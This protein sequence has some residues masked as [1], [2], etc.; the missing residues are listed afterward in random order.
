MT[1]PVR[2]I[3]VDRRLFVAAQG[4]VLLAYALPLLHAYL[5][6]E[7]IR[8]LHWDDEILYHLPLIQA[9][10]ESGWRIELEEYSSATPPLFHVVFAGL[11]RLFAENVWILRAVNVGITLAI[12]L[13]VMRALSSRLPPATTLSITLPI[14]F[15]PYIW[16]RGYA[17]LTESLATFFVVLAARA[18]FIRRWSHSGY[19]QAGVFL[20]LATATRHHWSYLAVALAVITLLS[21]GLPRERVVRALPLALPLLV[22]LACVAAWGGLV[23][24]Q[25]REANAARTLNWRAVVFTVTAL[26]FYGAAMNPSYLASL[27]RQPL[28]VFVSAVTGALLAVGSRL[29]LKSERTDNGY[30]WSTTAPFPTIAGA[31]VVLAALTMLGV[32][33]LLGRWQ[34]G[35]RAS[36]IIVGFLALS[37]LPVRLNFQKYYEVSMLLVTARV[38]ALER[39]EPLDLVGRGFFVVAGFCYVVAKVFL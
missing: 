33:H 6:G 36:V 32:L 11:Y 23:P 28:L 1:G 7:P 27:A 25:F 2:D 20:A 16:T 30:L 29:A 35:D 26:G 9:F 3:R 10:A 38:A 21:P 22:L 5:R 18:L 4:F 17:L 8:V 34:R 19:V 31:N 14:A 13:V 39:T 24:P 37:F 12:A 15:A